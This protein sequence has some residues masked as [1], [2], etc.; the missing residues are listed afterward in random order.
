MSTK[1]RWL[2]FA[3]A[4]ALLALSATLAAES[5]PAPQPVE[6]D[7]SSA[8][9]DDFFAPFLQ[10]EKRGPFVVGN[11]SFYLTDDSRS[12]GCGDGKRV[13]LTEVWYP[14]ADHAA[15][16]PEHYTRGF[17]LD[18]W[19]EAQRVV[20][21]DGGKML[22]NLPT[23]SYRDA[24]LHPRATRMPVLIFSHGFMST[25]FQNYTMASYLASHGYL[26][27]A[28]DH[29]CNAAVTLTPDR[30]V[31]GS[32]F[33][34]LTTI[35]Q[36]AGDLRFLMD[37]F[38]RNP[39]AEFAGRVDP[40]RLALWGHSMG[41][42]SASDKTTSDP[43]VKALLQIASFGFPYVPPWV[44]A[45]SMYFWGLE[46]KIIA[47]LEGLHRQSRRHMPKPRYLLNF[48]DT[49]HFAFADLC[50]FAVPLQKGNGCGTEERMTWRGTFTN[51]PHGVLH[52]ALNAYA[53]AFFGASLFQ[54]PELHAYLRENHFPELMTYSV[55]E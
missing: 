55:T 46:D 10:P 31:R 30:V 1:R 15:T 12:L 16:L 50:E 34:M 20:G 27:V 49:G 4:A 54:L 11:R 53:T 21:I 36:R 44:K 8:T 25:R 38:T 18:R 48:R 9:A 6:T 19:D 45:P 23:R 3:L 26:V 29:V 32:M 28:P 22:I 41:G 13:L 35:G 5:E 52:E 42:F 14:A 2:L 37:T 40:D 17:L 33:S 51:P 39:P 43:R 7:A 24:P 47:P